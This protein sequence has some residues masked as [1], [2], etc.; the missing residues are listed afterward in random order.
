MWSAVTSLVA[1]HLS[2]CKPRALPESPPQRCAETAVKALYD[3]LTDA[4][5]REICFDWDYRDRRGLLR[6]FVAN[7]WQVTRPA[8]RS[9]FFTLQQQIIIHDIFRGIINP[10]WYARFLK[11]LHDDTA[12]HPWGTN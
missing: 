3:S 1:Y 4:Q 5:K 9:D 8:I 10:D 6:S 7:H 2:G 11:Q 12:G